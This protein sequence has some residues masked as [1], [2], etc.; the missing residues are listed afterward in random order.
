MLETLFDGLP[1]LRSQSNTIP[2]LD[3]VDWIASSG[4]RADTDVRD[5]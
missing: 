5:D 4:W 1:K 2:E 3:V